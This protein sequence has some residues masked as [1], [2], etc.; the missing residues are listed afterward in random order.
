MASSVFIAVS[1]WQCASVRAG[2]D[3]CSICRTVA[4]ISTPRSA[5]VQR[6][7]AGSTSGTHGLRRHRRGRVHRRGAGSRV[8]SVRSATPRFAPAVESGVQRTARRFSWRR[9]APTGASAA[10]ILGTRETVFAGDCERPYFKVPAPS[11]PRN[12]GV[13]YSLCAAAVAVYALPSPQWNSSQS[14]NARGVR[15]CWTCSKRPAVDGRL[16]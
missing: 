5:S 9:C 1:H 8:R 14:C 16:R 4:K 12:K 15:R 6:T 7:S 2:M 11:T 3:G 10:R 13:P